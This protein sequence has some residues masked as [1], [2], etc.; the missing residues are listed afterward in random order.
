MHFWAL[1]WHVRM[2]S[3][4][5]IALGVIGLVR[6]IPIVLFSLMGGALAD[7]VN[8]RTVMILTQS[9]MML[10]AILLGILTLLGSIHLF[11]IYLLTAAQAV[12]QSFDLPARQALVPNLVPARDMPNAFSLNSIAYQIGSILGPALSGVTIATMDL[13]STY[14]IYAVTYV[15]AILALGM[16]GKVEQ[17]LGSRREGLRFAAIKEGVAFIW[18]RPI[19]LS[20]ML[21]D[22]FATFFSSANALMPIFARDIL[23]VGEVRYGWLAAAQAIRA[24]AA[25]LVISQV[26]EVR[27]QG[28][29]VL[30]SVALFGGATVL[31]GMSRA[32]W[33][34]ML[35]LMLIGATDTISAIIRNT[36]SQIRTPDAIRGRMVSVNQIFFMGGPQLGEI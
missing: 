27:R 31:F 22:F 34:S 9:T 6:V 35:A 19:I 23:H 25:A 2:L 32:F 11:W 14:L 20:S 18:N 5:P 24:T 15:F 28:P 8:R 26:N 36:I 17:N 7:V 10:I 33:L 13:Q 30:G 12:A 1:L 16:I 3:D 29:I 21:L 4:Q